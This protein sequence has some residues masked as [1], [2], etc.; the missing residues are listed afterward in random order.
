M[1]LTPIY[2]RL[3]VSKE[4][5]AGGLIPK[6]PAVA[7]HADLITLPADVEGTNCGNCRHVRDKGKGHYCNHPEL[8]KSPV[9]ERMC[10]KY[11][12]NKGVIRHFEGKVV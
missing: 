1:H 8:E 12:D 10:C 6:D 3:A 9:N 4:D 2:S 11:W 7:K 5:E